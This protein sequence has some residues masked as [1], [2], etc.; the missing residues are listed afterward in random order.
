MQDLRVKIVEYTNLTEVHASAGV[1]ISIVG[2]SLEDAVPGSQLLFIDDPRDSDEVEDK[3]DLVQQGMDALTNLQRSDEG[4][5]IVASTLGALEALFGF[6]KDEIKIPIAGISIGTVRR[7]DVMKASV[8]L[9]RKAEYA[10]I[11][12]FDVT[13]APDAA[14]LAEETG[15]QIMTAEIIYQLQ[16]QFKDYIENVSSNFK[17]E[18]RDK[19]VFPVLMTII[20]NKVF[21]RKDPI[22]FGVEILRGSLRLNTPI[23]ALDEDSPPLFIGRVA[24]IQGDEKKELEKAEK[25]MKVAIRIDLTNENSTKIEYKRHFTEKA[26]LISRLSRDS[27]DCLKM[28][29]KDEL[30][31]KEK[32]TELRGRSSETAKAHRG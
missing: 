16:V 5:F 21:A 1:R 23:C 25:G 29:F 2:D 22:I 11:L 20:P 13:I 24:S 31:K 19:V 14:E 30:N 3:K 15:I 8:M 18:Y 17:E 26:R 28:Y 27:I 4:V 7:K 32:S 6:V 12:A 10:V 9:E